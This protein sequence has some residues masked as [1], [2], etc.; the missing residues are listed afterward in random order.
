VLIA[1]PWAARREW[2]WLRAHW[3]EAL[4]VVLMPVA[5]IVGFVAAYYTP[6]MRPAIAEFGRYAFPAI[7]PIALLVVGALH[8]FGRR[9]MLAAAVALLV[10]M[11]ALS[12]AAQLLTLTGFYA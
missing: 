7:G 4:A 12:Y 3:A 9:R 1:A 10:A 5:V 11:I 2:P 6:G 8:A